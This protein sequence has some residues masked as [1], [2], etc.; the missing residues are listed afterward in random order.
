MSDKS[1]DYRIQLGDN[2]IVTTKR[3][4]NKARTDLLLKRLIK[5]VEKY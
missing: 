5:A 3:K 1:K 2:I 4:P